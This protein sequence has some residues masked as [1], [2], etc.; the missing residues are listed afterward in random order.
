[1]A[2]S[3]FAEPAFIQV[4]EEQ[5][6]IG[7][8]FPVDLGIVGDAKIVAEQ[9]ASE[10]ERRGHNA[11]GRRTADTA[12]AIA[13]ERY[14]QSIE[15]EGVEEALDPRLALIRL[16]QVLPEDR[17][18]VSDGGAIIPWIGQYL[19]TSD[20]RSFFWPHNYFSVGTGSGVA[21]G[22]AAARGERL[23]VLACGDGAFMMTLNDLD[24]AVRY[25]LRL[26][27]FIMNDNGFGQ[28]VHQLRMEG[29]PD[30]IA[31]YDSP[32]FVDIARAMGADAV[33]LQTL[34]DIDALRERVASMQG[35][36][37]VDC[38]ISRDVYPE[39]TDFVHRFGHRNEPAV[40]PSR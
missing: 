14:E 7:F 3:S 18:V 40:L 34:S 29:L 16:N 13:N 33:C 24:T 22:V 8:H 39:G 5:E 9:L 10:L 21:L 37:L 17:A 28:E 27:V 20:P 4:D 38:P 26:L 1:L 30:A 32:S 11:T 36:L 31:V 19:M 2:G 12:A 35:P 15:D 25:G 23:T 6:A